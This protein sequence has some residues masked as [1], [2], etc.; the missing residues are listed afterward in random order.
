MKELLEDLAARIYEALRN[1]KLIP[2]PVPANNGSRD[3]S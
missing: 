2:V 1:K 3:N